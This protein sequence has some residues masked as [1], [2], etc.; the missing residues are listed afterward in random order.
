MDF[1]LEV[2]RCPRTGQ[3]LHEKDGRLVTGDGTLAY[4]IENG[5]PVLLAEEAAQVTR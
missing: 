1:L 4:R 2:A 5:I 3:K